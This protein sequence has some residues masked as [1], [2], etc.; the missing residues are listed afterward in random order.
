MLLAVHQPNLLPRLK[1]LQKIGSADA[2][3]VLDSVQYVSREYQ[4]RTWL[5]PYNDESRGF[6]L[7][8]PTHRPHG[9]ESLV[10]D[11]LIVDQAATRSRFDTSI[12]RCFGAAPGWPA[13]EQVWKPVSESFSSGRLVDVCVASTIALLALCDR[14]PDVI[15][16]SRLGV[17]GGGSELMADICKSIGA[18]H[19]LADS[20]ATAYLHEADFRTTKV[21]WQEWTEPTTSHPTMIRSWR[22]ISSVNLLARDGSSALRGH[23][24]SGSFRVRS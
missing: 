8:I 1:V 21:L 14:T 2:W 3:V 17:Q 9:R 6:W 18:T 10:R 4:N 19:Y 12:D 23:V 15:L 5:V 11:C 13:I 20:G 7:S 24:G 22:D 16:A